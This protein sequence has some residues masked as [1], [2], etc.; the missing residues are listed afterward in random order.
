MYI[1]T[2]SVKNME[3]IWVGDNYDTFKPYDLNHCTFFGK[4][5]VIF[6]AAQK[7]LEI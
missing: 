2:Y 1:Y 7:T 6:F 5:E 4:H 3:Q